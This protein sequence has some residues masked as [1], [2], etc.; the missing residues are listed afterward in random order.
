MD[1]DVGITGKLSFLQ[2]PEQSFY[3]SYSA[4]MKFEKSKP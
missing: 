2:T 4:N 1:V 3:V